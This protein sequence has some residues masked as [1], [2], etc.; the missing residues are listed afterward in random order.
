LIDG[1][2]TQRCDAVH[3]KLTIGPEDR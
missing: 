1:R 2:H 3:N